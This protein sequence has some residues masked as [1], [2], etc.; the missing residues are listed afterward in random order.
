M[1]ENALPAFEIADPSEVVAAIDAV[2]AGEA[3]FADC[4]GT[5]WAGDV[6]DDYVRLAAARPELFPRST[7]AERDVETYLRRVD[8]DYEGA[9]LQSALLSQGVDRVAVF[10]ALRSTLAAELRPRRWLL[11]AML[12]AADRGVKLWAVSASGRIPVDVGLD[13]LGVAD[14]FGVI[15]VEVDDRGPIAPWSIGFGKVHA[16]RAAG[17][18]APAVAVGDSVWD[19]PMLADARHGFRL[20]KPKD[21]GRFDASAADL[22]AGR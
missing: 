8:H 17:L 21:D 10:A 12:Q 19:G 9:C 1:S 6:G 22:R 2:S 11:D 15:A 13:L 16:C 5:L 14:R 7:A 18:A 4:D 20:P 3:I